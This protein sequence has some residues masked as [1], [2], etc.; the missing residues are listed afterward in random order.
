MAS[1]AC[2]VGAAGAGE[3]AAAGAEVAAGPGAAAGALAAAGAGAA[4][5]AVYQSCV[6]SQKFSNESFI[7]NYIDH[8]LHCLSLS[9]MVFLNGDPQ[10]LI[11][12]SPQSSLH[13]SWPLDPK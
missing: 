7:T 4:D 10:Y 6:S 13:L 3:E 2:A 9:N 11:F 8:C 5:R 12:C 1:T